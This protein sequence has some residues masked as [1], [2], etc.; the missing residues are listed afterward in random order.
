METEIRTTTADDWAH[1]REIRLRALADS[2]DSFGITLDEARRQPESIWRERASGPGPTLLVV[3][4]GRPLAMGGAFPVSEGGRAIIWG[5]WTAPEARRQG[6]AHRLLDHLVAW[7]RERHLEV[8]L[9]V[10]EGNEGARQ[11]YHDYGFRPTG[12]WRQ[13]REGSDLQ[14]ELLQL[15]HPGSSHGDPG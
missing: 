12:E 14:V 8:V 9:H 2:P 13:L 6:H 10:T 7:C 4:A 15:T 3:A 11:L 5:M 1:F